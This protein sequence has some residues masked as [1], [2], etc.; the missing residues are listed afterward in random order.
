VRTLLAV[1]VL[2][3]GVA[4]ATADA[5]TGLS[6]QSRRAQL[7]IV[8]TDP[9]VVRGVRFAP[10]ERVKLLVAVGGRSVRTSAVRAS[11]AGRFR[12]LLQASA[13]ASEAVVVQAIGARGSRASADVA[14]PTGTLAPKP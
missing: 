5:E 11:R 2:A 7:F 6:D 14:A 9:L 13:V 4:C 8:S 12:V 10:G 1:S 3:F